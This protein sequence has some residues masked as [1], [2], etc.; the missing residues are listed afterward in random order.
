MKKIYVILFTVF[1][2]VAL[3]SC[4]PTSLQEESPS[5]TVGCCGEDGDLDPPPPPPPPPPGGK[6]IKG[7][8]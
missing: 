7:V 3:F 6:S 4:T 8:K 2:N 1:L 5:A